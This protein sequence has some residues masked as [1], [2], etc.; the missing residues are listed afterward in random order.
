MKKRYVSYEN[1]GAITTESH[2]SDLYMCLRE[3]TIWCSSDLETPSEKGVSFTYMPAALLEQAVPEDKRSSLIAIREQML[4]VLCLRHLPPATFYDSNQ[5]VF[6]QLRS[7]IDAHSDPKYLLHE[8]YSLNSKEE[9]ALQNLEAFG[10]ISNLG[11]EVWHSEPIIADHWNSK[12]YFTEK[13]S[14]ILGSDSVSPGITLNTH[15]LKEVVKTTEEF[16][17]DHISKVILKLNNSGG[18]GNLI[19]SNDDNFSLYIKEFIASKK[20]K[21]SEWIR[22]EHVVPW[23]F[24]FCISFFI[25]DDSQKPVLMGFCEQILNSE[26]FEFAGCTSILPISSEDVLAIVDNLRP[27]VHQMQQDGVRGFVG[28]DV[29]VS[30]TDAN[31]QGLLLPSGL[32]MKVIEANARLNGHNVIITFISHVAAK[33]EVSLSQMVFLNLRNLPVSGTKS[34]AD[35]EQAII[36]FLDGYA[37]QYSGEELNA[38]TLY[39]ILVCNFGDTA[40][41][42][43]DSIILFGK[44]GWTILDKIVQCYQKFTNYSWLKGSWT[45]CPIEYLSY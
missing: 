32:A 45:S 6:L 7:L 34:R 25:K 42:T 26:K 3:K 12:P 40:P 36:A 39:F 23:L 8:G 44:S 38:N 20:D 29:I 14:D 11:I 33:H 18:R 35:V 2:T 22:I 9:G 1:Y 19:V 16:F 41:N 30:E 10:N 4:D 43:S 27:I 5:S 31:W 37:V 17:A 28:I 24:S 15:D 21:D 13:V